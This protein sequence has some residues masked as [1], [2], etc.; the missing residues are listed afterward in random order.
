MAAVRTALEETSKTGEFVRVAS[1]YRSR[2]SPDGQYPPVA[3]R[4]HLYVSYACPWAHRTLILR[5][6]KGL[7]DAISVSVVHPTWQKTRPDDPEDKHCGWAFTSPDGEPLVPP[8]GHGSLDPRDT[9]PDPVK[10]FP[11]VRAIYDSVEDTVGKYTVPILYDKETGTIV[12]NESA[13]IIEMLNK[14]FNA[15]A[16]HPEV[17]VF[18]EDLLGAIDA[19]NEWVYPGINNGVYR[20]GFATSQGAYD[21]AVA[22]LFESLDRMEAILAENRYLCGDQLTAADV[23]AY[24]TLV[25][26]DEVYVVYF[27]CNKAR[28][29]D[30]PNI[31]N[32]LRELWQMPAFKDTTNM[33]HIKTH[34]FTSHPTLNHYS[35]VPAGPNVLADLAKPHDRDRF[36]S[37]AASKKARVE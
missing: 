21:K 25:R 16:K 5:K 19:I 13:E 12:N 30:Y 35:V 24:V 34:Y 1:G 36:S 7:E 10:G 26:F 33:Y 11:N 29:I 27:K 20:C 2:I 17:D 37:G 15:I 31:Q 6:L 3:G 32:Y 28:I 4:Y 18:P 23:R 14:E 8:S 9:I 22:E